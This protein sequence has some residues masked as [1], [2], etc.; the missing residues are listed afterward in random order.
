[1]TAERELADTVH[2]LVKQHVAQQT[3]RIAILE[4]ERSGFVTRGLELERKVNRLTEALEEATRTI[5]H[6]REDLRAY[7]ER[8]AEHRTT[9]H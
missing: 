6:Q 3:K 7:A 1:M 2:N 8:E 4:K 5:R 9:S